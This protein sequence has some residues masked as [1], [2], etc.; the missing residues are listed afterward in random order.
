MSKFTA[1]GVR[2]SAPPPLPLVNSPFVDIGQKF[3]DM[4]HF[5]A[6]LMNGFYSGV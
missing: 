4:Q 3:I 5:V 6:K 1:L 2:S